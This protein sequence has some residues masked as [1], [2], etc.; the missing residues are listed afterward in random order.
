M[1]PQRKSL[2]VAFRSDPAHKKEDLPVIG[3]PSVS[4]NVALPYIDPDSTLLLVALAT[5]LLSSGSK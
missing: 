1:I 3:K 2:S 4:R 5:T